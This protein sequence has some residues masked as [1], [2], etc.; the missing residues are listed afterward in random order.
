MRFFLIFFPK[1]I[2][3]FGHVNITIFVNQGRIKYEIHIKVATKLQN[4]NNKK[5]QKCMYQPRVE[6]CSFDFLGLETLDLE[7]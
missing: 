7:E 3:H 5:Q 4:N 1:N 2:K 6:L